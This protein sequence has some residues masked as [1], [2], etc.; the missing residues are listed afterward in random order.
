MSRLYTQLVSKIIFPLQE[1]LKKH[2]TVRARRSLERSQWLSPEQIAAQQLAELK[3]FLI[4]IGLHVP[5]YREAFARIG[6]KPESL[7]S[8]ADLAQLPTLTK[9]LIR[10]HAEAL[11][12]EHAGPLGRSSTGGSSGTPLQFFIS[13][14]RVSH[15]VAA[16]WRATRWWDVDIG[17]RE[18]VVWASP[19][20]L[21]AQDRVRLFRD[22]LMRSTLLNA[23]AMNEKNLDH[24]VQRLR[25]IR[26]AMVFGYPYS[27]ALISAH[28]KKRGVRLD[29]LGVKVVFVTSEYLHDHQRELISEVFGCKVANGYGG[30]DAG[31]IAHECPEGGMH[32]TA[33]DIVVELLGEDGQPVADGQPGE[34]TVTHL[35]TRDYPFLRYRTGDVAVRDTRRCACGRGLP[36][37]REI[38]GRT[39]DFLRATD[40]TML[41]CGA[42][43]YLMRETEGITNYKIIQETQLLT[44][45]EVV[46][47]G[48]LDQATRQKLIDGLKFRLGRE[49]EI[50]VELLDEIPAQGNGKYRYVVSKLQ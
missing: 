41:P 37:L 23:F 33:E 6:F 42:F 18:V 10:D 39:N 25:E 28:A 29:D 24:Y 21:H 12:H 22:A 49:V 48:G 26:P 43:T 11:K 17:D 34:V 27:I 36:L 7:Q 3:T 38:Q 30:R 32:I 50:Q 44:R 14:E 35:R 19:I 4:D 13:L 9:P 16:K 15:D 46:R 1:R 8:L 47:P 45:L 20:E 2:D 5:Y 31:F 40:G